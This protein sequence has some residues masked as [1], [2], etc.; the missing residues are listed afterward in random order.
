MRK[1]LRARQMLGSNA[2]VPLS[3]KD[4]LIGFH[5]TLLCEAAR[6]LSG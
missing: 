2:V 4:A 6:L 1:M 5:S 3:K